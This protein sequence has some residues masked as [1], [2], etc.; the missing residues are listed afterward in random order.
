MKEFFKEMFET[1][2]NRKRR[3]TE[4]PVEDE[5]IQDQSVEPEQTE[6]D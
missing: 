5:T 6:L 1:G 3:D 2:P 4:K